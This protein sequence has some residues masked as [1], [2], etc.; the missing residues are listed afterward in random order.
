MNLNTLY[1]EKDRLARSIQSAVAVVGAGH[2]PA[3]RSSTGA[4][5]VSVTRAGSRRRSNVARC[6]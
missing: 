4:V 6:R 2:P 3:L 5:A 1:P